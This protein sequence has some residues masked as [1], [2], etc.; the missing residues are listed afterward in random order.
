MRARTELQVNTWTTDLQ[1]DDGVYMNETDNQTAIATS[2]IRNTLRVRR[3]FTVAAALTPEV[4]TDLQSRDNTSEHV[5]KP[6]RD[7]RSQSFLFVVAHSHVN[8]SKRSRWSLKRKNKRK[9]AK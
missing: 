8:K 1:C 2:N 3:E 4:P 7:R 9:P 5:V 6:T